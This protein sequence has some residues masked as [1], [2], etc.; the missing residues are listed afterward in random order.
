MSLPN[1]SPVP[2]SLSLMLALAV[3]AMSLAGCGREAPTAALSPE[4]APE[5]AL[6]H[7]KKHLDPT[8]VCPMHPR[9]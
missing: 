6:E 8:Y 9:W 5:T 1:Q 2:R 7:A 3:V 4:T